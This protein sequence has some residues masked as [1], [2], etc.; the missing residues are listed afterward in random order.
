MIPQLGRPTPNAGL[1]AAAA[2]GIDLSTH[3]SVW[4]ARNMAEAASLLIVFDNI[5]R[6][7]VLDRYPNLNVPIILLGDL[8]GLSEIT[9]PVDSST[10][11][12]IRVYDEI[13]TAITE[14]SLL[15]RGDAQ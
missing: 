11:V 5:T 8:T 2:Y 7:A 12:F 10:A 14:L 13:A 3:R 4:L 15:M 6:S 1:Q 9:D